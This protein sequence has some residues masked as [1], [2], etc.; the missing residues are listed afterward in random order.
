MD[1]ETLNR[2]NSIKARM[3]DIRYHNC[4]GS[5]T[6]SPNSEENKYIPCG[7][8]DEYLK[9]NNKLHNIYKETNQL[10]NIFQ[11]KDI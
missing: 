1:K 8:C 4:L 7:L 10:I 2:I 6:L 3:F 9:L 5:L 11:T